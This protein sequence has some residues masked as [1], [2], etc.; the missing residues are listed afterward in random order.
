MLTAV[1]GETVLDPLYFGLQPADALRVL[2][3]LLVSE[4][5]RDADARTATAEQLRTLV[6]AWHEVND[7][8]RL[9]DVLALDPNSKAGDPRAFERTLTV[10]GERFG[11]WPYDLMRRPWVEIDAVIDALE[12]QAGGTGSVSPDNAELVKRL[13]AQREAGRA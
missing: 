7:W 11:C 13:S 8:K 3:P 4:L 5:L 12:R 10:L 2:A 6:A 1:G 9:K